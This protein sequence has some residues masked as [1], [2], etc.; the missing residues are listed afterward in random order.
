MWC[1]RRR[2]IYI[3]PIGVPRA[4]GAVGVAL[5]AATGGLIGV[6]LAAESSR[7]VT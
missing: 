3:D 7:D 1:G 2:G 5:V 6:R 4:L